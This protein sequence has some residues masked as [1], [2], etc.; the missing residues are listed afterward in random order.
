MHS[1]LYARLFKPQNGSKHD[2]VG[3]TVNSWHK[4]LHTRLCRTRN[5]VYDTLC[6]TLDFLRHVMLRMIEHIILSVLQV[7]IPLYIENGDTL[8]FIF[9]DML[10]MFQAMICMLRYTGHDIMCIYFI[11]FV[12]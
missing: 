2:T 10:Y 7:T 6:D 8:G 12:V 1:D 3:F 11:L 5:T 4:L 9:H